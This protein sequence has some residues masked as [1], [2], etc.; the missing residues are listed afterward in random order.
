MVMICPRCG[1][2]VR[3]NRSGTI[4]VHRRPRPASW[5]RGSQRICAAS[6]WT[7]D[8]LRAFIRDEAREQKEGAQ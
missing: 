5:A 8:G 2:T 4:R 7:P 6:G 3:V 1:A